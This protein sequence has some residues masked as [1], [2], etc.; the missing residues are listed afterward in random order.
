[1]KLISDLKSDI[2]FLW[3]KGLNIVTWYAI[4]IATLITAAYYFG[5]VE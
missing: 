2:K 4:Y 1:M 3:N 5:I